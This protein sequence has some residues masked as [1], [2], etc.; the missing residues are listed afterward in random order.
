MLM[1]ADPQEES[2]SGT[3]AYLERRLLNEGPPPEM[4]ERWS[5]QRRAV[6]KSAAGKIRRKAERGW[7]HNKLF[8]YL[9][10]AVCLAIVLKLGDRGLTAIWRH[11][12]STGRPSQADVHQPSSATSPSVLLHP[13]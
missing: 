9:M 5:A 7:S 3:A 6:S 13:R 10:I 8:F 4:P 2:S 1:D 11:V 12:I